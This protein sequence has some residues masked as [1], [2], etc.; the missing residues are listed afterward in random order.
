MGERLGRENFT[1][2]PSSS[3]PRQ[4][5]L[6]SLQQELLDADHVEHWFLSYIDLLQRFQLWNVANQVIQLAG[7]TVTGTTVPMPRSEGC[8][9]MLG[10]LLSHFTHFHG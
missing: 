4:P 6:P 8:I 7:K 9:I 10:N 2:T 5:T 3:F 1:Y